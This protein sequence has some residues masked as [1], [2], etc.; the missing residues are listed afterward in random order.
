MEIRDKVAIVTGGGRGIGRTTALSLAR[1]GARAVAL[2]DVNEAVLA[3]A[4]EEV[5]KAGAEALPITCDVGDLE[6]LREMFVRVEGACGRID[7]LHNNAGIGEGSTDWPDVPPERAG[8]IVDVNLRGVVLGTR[9]ALDPMRRA[10]GGVVV[11]TAS[12]AA[13]APLPPQAVYAATKA[14]V[15]HFTKAC[16]ASSGKSAFSKH[17]AA[18]RWIPACSYISAATL[19]LLALE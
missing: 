4:A 14:A 8:A 1:E 19:K 17:S 5:K 15:V 10:G 16:A 6:S 2:V 3:E 11:N 7:I 12:G 18:L 13:F 9:L